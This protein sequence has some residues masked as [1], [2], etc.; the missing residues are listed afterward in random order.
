MSDLL[1]EQGLL[2]IPTQVLYQSDN[3]HKLYII[4][5]SITL[6]NFYTLRFGDFTLGFKTILEWK[7]FDIIN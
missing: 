1:S 4:S 2:L 3:L 5:V 6:G 7:T